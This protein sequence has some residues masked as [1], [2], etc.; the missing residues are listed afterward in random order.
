MKV[1]ELF[2]SALAAEARQDWPRAISDYQRILASDPQHADA[3]NNLAAIAARG[4]QRQEAIGLFR[5]A[6]RVCPLHRAATHNL[7]RNLAAT[8]ELAEADTFYARL[9]QQEADADLWV[10]RIQAQ[11]NGGNCTLAEQLAQTALQDYPQHTALWL[12]RGNA[13]LY[14][15]AAT[16]AEAHYRKS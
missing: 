3:L 6:L 10:E 13:A 14:N 2:R 16:R 5:L 8:G 9:I 15:E 7:A 11:V 4:G 12:A 1:D